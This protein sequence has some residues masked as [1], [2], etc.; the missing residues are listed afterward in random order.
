MGPDGCPDL[1]LED[2]GVTFARGAFH[3]E[4]DRSENFASWRLSTLRSTKSATHVV[5]FIVRK[6]SAQLRATSFE[7]RATSIVS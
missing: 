4:A 3:R 1:H 7:A 6:N 5:R 2:H